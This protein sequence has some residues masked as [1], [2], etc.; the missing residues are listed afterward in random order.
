M[1]LYQA[2]CVSPIGGIV[3]ISDTTQLWAVDYADYV[4]RMYRRL[5]R[6]HG[7]YQLRRA[8][9]PLGAIQRLQAYFA[10]DWQALAGLPVATRGTVFQQ[11]VWSELRQIPVGTTVSYQQLA[12]RLG[13]PRAC[14]AVG[15]ANAANP[16]AIVVPCHR[17]IGSQQE[18]TGYS[19]GL[20]RK[21]W[22][23]K[24]ENASPLPAF[25]HTD[26]A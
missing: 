8:I 15:L 21:R 16:L 17:V 12:V 10:G 3:V 18:L 14:R 13:R 7:D 20:K 2:E 11:Q 24:H 25:L 19:G 1:V 9:D 23:L 26:R 22:L 6:H 5:Q 4:E